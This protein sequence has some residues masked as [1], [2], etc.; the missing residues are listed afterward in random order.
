M[1]MHLALTLRAQQN[2]SRRRRDGCGMGEIRLEIARHRGSDV[3]DD[4]VGVGAL[5]MQ[6]RLTVHHVHII[7]ACFSIPVPKKILK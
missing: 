1:A 3:T 6:P 4:G 5:P 2:S 7:L